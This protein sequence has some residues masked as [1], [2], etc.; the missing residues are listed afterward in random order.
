[1]RPP[2]TWK[3][4]PLTAGLAL[5]TIAAWLV[6]A[7]FQQE[8]RAIELFGF[9][10][11]AGIL[12]SPVPVWL[13]PLT[14]TL[15]HAGFAHLLFNMIVLVFCGRPVETVLGTP[16]MAILYVL[17]AYAAEGHTTP[18]NWTVTITNSVPDVLERVADAWQRVF[19]VEARVTHQGAR[20]QTGFRQNLKTV[21]DSQYWPAL[22]DETLHGVHDW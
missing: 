13:Q 15:V 1:M 2:D 11:H 7:L 5:A 21:A 10:P 16:A 6:A 14:A 22:F 9:L 4:A 19:G 8:E 20:E 12:A 18:S 3:K 17:G